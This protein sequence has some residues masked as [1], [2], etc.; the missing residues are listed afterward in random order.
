MVTAAKPKQHSH[1]FQI[2]NIG[3]GV[4]RGTC[5]CGEIREYSGYG[6]EAT[7]KVI[8]AG[9]PNYQDGKRQIVV[10]HTDEII[11]ELTGSTTKPA[12]NIP[13]NIPEK[14][15]VEAKPTEAP[16][17]N[18]EILANTSGKIITHDRPN[19]REGYW[20]WMDEHK[21]QVLKDYQD[22][23]IRDFLLRWH[24]TTVTWKKLK[25]RWNITGKRTRG[26]DRTATQPAPSVS[27]KP[28]NVSEMADLSTKNPEV[29]TENLGNFADTLPER[30][31]YPRLE[32][33]RDA[34]S[35]ISLKLG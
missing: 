6:K 21:G 1:S 16:A 28:E 5:K 10:D 11:N 35:A 2:E 4:A 33:D 19:N 9:D 22:M 12:E 26:I 23:G 3:K 27:Q 17:Q 8:Q 25:E 29:S 24:I 14:P 13:D 15:Q 34:R 7:I 31:V 32:P 30:P 20:K 18:A